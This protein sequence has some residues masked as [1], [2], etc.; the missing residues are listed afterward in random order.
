VRVSTVL[1][2]S[3]CQHTHACRPTS[4]MKYIDLQTETEEKARQPETK[5]NVHKVYIVFDSRVLSHR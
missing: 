3:S 2:M 4:Y 5:L 1:L